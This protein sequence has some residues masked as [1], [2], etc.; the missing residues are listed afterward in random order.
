MLRRSLA[1]AWRRIMAA[2]CALVIGAVTTAA[3]P[4]SPNTTK[5]LSPAD[6]L[7]SMVVRP[8]FEVELV[9][10]EPLTMDPTAF[11]WGADGKLW[12]VEMADYPLGID[13]KGK[14]GGRVRYLEDTDGDGRYDRSTLFLDGLGYPTGVMP[15]R[16]GV[17]VTC[18][19]EILYAEDTDGDGQADVRKTLFTGFGEGNQQHRVNGLRYGLDNW[20]YCANGDSGG[21]IISKQTGDKVD[22]SGRD[23]RL[24][25]DEGLI[26]A[27]AGQSQ[28]LRDR[29][30]WGNWF[31]N[32]NSNPMFHLVLEDRYLR[33]NPHL[34]PP[35]VKV[36]VSVAPGASPVYPASAT[37]QRFN[38]LSRA[39]RFTSA[40]SAMIYRDD[41]FGPEFVGNSFVCEP[42]H[43]LVHREVVTATGVT[44][45]S[46]RA[47]DEKQSEFFASR[48]NWSR[49]AMVRSGPDG[50][51]WVADM[52]RHVIEHP[53]WIPKQ[54]QQRLDLRAGQDKGR[55]Y[56][57]FPTAMKPRPIPRLDKLDTTG[58]VAALDSP[59]G[60]QRDMV[61]QL[62]IE[63]RDPTAIPLLEQA[64]ADVKKRPLCRLHALCTLDGLLPALRPETLLTALADPAAGVRR[65]AVRLSEPLLAKSTVVGEALVVGEAILEMADDADSQVRLQVAYTLG[66]WRDPRVGSVLGKMALAAATDRYTTAAILSSIN[67]DNLLAALEA[68]LPVD[69]T[70]N[71]SPP[72]DLVQKLLALAAAFE[73]DEA[74]VRALDAIAEPVGQ[75]TIDNKT[76]PKYADWQLTALSGLLDTLDRR[77]MPLARFRERSS[78]RLRVALDHL[79]EVFDS[80]RA[81]ATNQQVAE[82]D[83]I[84]ALWL[85][86]HGPDRR[87]ADIESL[88]ALLVPQNSGQLQTAV[89]TALGKLNDNRVPQVLLDGWKGFGPDLRGRIL[90]VLLSRG[91]WANLLF[92]RLEKGEVLAAEIDAPRRLRLLEQKDA[93]LRTRAE[94]LLA[95]AVSND[96]RKVIDDYRSALSLPANKVQGAAVF[97]KTCSACHRL[98]ELGFPVGPDLTALTDRSP[99]SMLVAVLD[100]NRAVEAKFINYVA[101]TN[102][103]LIHTGMLAAE[104]GNSITLLAGE[105]KQTI[106]LRADLESLTSSSKSLM[107]EG[108][109]KDL[110]P[111]NVADLL[112]FLGSNKPSRKTFEGNQPEVVKP[113][114]LRG[115]FW[116]LASQCEIYGT[117]LVFER[118]AGNLGYWQSENDLAIWTFEVAEP[119][120]Y[121]VSLEYACADASAGNSF[122]LAIEQ[123]RLNGKVTGTGNWET[124]RSERLGQ[125]TLTAGRRELVVRSDGEPKGALMDLRSVRLRP[126]KK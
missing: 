50:A 58:L 9:A 70:S 82:T 69:T 94:K 122:I 90:D 118:S 2:I 34:S 67:K 10:A 66:E 41:L 14:F 3:E 19:P 109:E 18:A 92:D 111:Q 112:A 108:V 64:A 114:A 88:G 27:V 102:S 125:V 17:L 79:A 13:G 100:P 97:K 16:K 103:G 55:V 51:L 44:F 61:Q 32:N 56:R 110:T 26:E 15:W 89:V 106:L 22:V 53:E 96:R 42:V 1:A 76:V 84:L 120:Q 119:G 45:T 29:D 91:P 38:D 28:F 104:T 49:P 7:R 71:T 57:I 25:P 107:P 21:T 86:G 52:Y 98:G 59:S 83:R 115:E 5:P 47:D 81:T 48:D 39:N 12:I 65:H 30:D 113:E 31:G 99:D 46:R 74:L 73:N 117:T 85:M 20:V 23:L 101:I 87:N 33:R 123:N 95:G 72:A 36:Q 4:P 35:D 6:A 60:W 24:K 75:R 121:D 11:A 105:G 68:V 40:C 8:G 37:V 116:L 62:L 93:T 43:N 78:G 63:R 77:Q 126:S 80:A 54:W 124:F